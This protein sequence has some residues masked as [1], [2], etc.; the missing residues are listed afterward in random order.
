M[1]EVI[2]NWEANQSKKSSQPQNLE[3]CFEWLKTNVTGYQEF[4]AMSEQDICIMHNGI[5]RWIR[6]TLGFWEDYDKP[7]DKKRPLVKWF[8]NMG[9]IHPDDMSSMLLTC[10]HRHLNNK[11]LCIEEEADAC[12]QFWATQPPTLTIQTIP[13]NY[14]N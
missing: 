12:V 5:G 1:N 13:K 7:A 8:N 9:V 4:A 14:G 3:E 6:N 10:F 2:E 11:E